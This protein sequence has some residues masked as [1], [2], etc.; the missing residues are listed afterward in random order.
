MITDFL[1][2]SIILGAVLG[3]AMFGRNWFDTMSRRAKKGGCQ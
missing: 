1:I 2:S 3:L